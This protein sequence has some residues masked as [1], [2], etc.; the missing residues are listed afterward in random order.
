M[1]TQLQ[2]RLVAY[3]WSKGADSKAIAGILAMAEDH[4][5]D[6]LQAIRVA[7]R[8]PKVEAAE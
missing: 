5:V 4:V 1:I 6:A 3:H 2:L 8:R 7:N